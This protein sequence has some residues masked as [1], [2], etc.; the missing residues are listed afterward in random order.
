MKKTLLFILMSL[1]S[2]AGFAQLKVS[3]PG[4]IPE[5]QSMEMREGHV[6]VNARMKYFSN[7]EAA[8]RAAELFNTFLE[9]NYKL[10]LEKGTI[11]NA[12]LIFSDDEMLPAEGYQ[13]TAY[14]T[15]IVLQGHEAGLFY[16]VQTLQQLITRNKTLIYV[17]AVTIKDQPRFAYRGLM[18]DVGRHFFPV[19]YIKQFIDVMAHYKLNRFHWHLT[20]DQGW[21]IEIKKY[22][23]LQSVASQRKETMMGPYRDGKYDGKPYGGYYTQEE[24]KDVVKYAADRFITVVPEIEMPGHAQA[25][26]AAY[27][28]LGCTGGPYEVSTKW[29]VHKEVYCAGNDSVFAFLEDVLNEVMPLFPGQYVHIGGDECPKDRWK[30]CPKCQARMKALGLKDEHE[31]QSY[32][33]QRMEK[34]LNSKGKKIIG[35]DEILEGGLA[36]DATVMSWR[37]EA[38]GIAAAKQKH[39]VI[40]TPNTYLYLDYHQGNPATEPLGIG[41]YL[42]LEKVYS[43]EPYPPTLSA[44][45]K[46]YIKGVQGNVWTEYIPD[47]KGVDYFTYPRA[48]ALAEI[49]WSPASKKNYR[50]FK[51]K[52]KGALEDLDAR[53]VNFRIPEAM[54]AENLVLSG[55]STTVTLK[56]VSGGKIF[57]TTD[58]TLPSPHGKAYTKPIVIAPAQKATVTLKYIVVLPSG[59]S[60][61]VYSNTYTRKPYKTA[62]NVSPP[63]KGVQF[64]VYGKT[65]QQARQIGGGTADSSGAA[66]DFSIR[67]FM[68][69]VKYGVSFEGYI[70]I[71]E[72]GLYEFKTNS[73][74]G[75]VLAID[76]EL[77]VDNDGE[78]GAVEKTG[79][80]PLLKGYHKIRLQYFNV[81][82]D[83]SLQVSF[84]LKGKQSINLRNALFH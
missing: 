42:P 18:L 83:Q 16:A 26:L 79:M 69:R 8:E 12:T 82:G 29:G 17:P 52:L 44:E 47:D 15:K 55:A 68:H 28:N 48:L 5:P 80:V 64:S 22:P 6:P 56:P 81:G 75:S 61:A 58:G 78:H 43:Y 35:W 39:D 30:E 34:F 4:I 37:G 21:R 10:R 7:S 70:K 51:E 57:Y 14:R 3:R 1:A 50:T 49:A 72:T 84:G 66:P 60:S 53:G 54:G 19:S 63:R 65:F 76:D 2:A 33:I 62:R 9:A 27:P 25:A 59:R 24:V 46:K 31:L 40:M 11:K 77:I 67:P 71:D 38:G 36:P 74:D 23:R 20:E 41:G 45:E 13:L 73:D 32:F